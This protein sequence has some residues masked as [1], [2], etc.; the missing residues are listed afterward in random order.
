MEYWYRNTFKSTIISTQM[1]QQIYTIE[2]ILKD[3]NDEY[4]LKHPGQNP[5]V[6]IPSIFAIPQAK[7]NAN[8]TVDPAGANLVLKTFINEKTGEIRTYLSK[9]INEPET[10][11]L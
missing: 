10:K 3:L 7:I 8:K 5:W 6:P 1:A 11:E 9:L 4:Q 2:Q